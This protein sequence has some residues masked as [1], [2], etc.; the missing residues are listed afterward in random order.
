MLLVHELTWMVLNMLLLTQLRKLR[1]R[2]LTHVLLRP[3][4]GTQSRRH[5]NTA[6]TG[7]ASLAT[8]VRHHS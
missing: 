7:T 6:T 1:Y 4:C 8:L 5:W 2:L 3:R